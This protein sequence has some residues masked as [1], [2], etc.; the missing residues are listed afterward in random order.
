MKCDDRLSLG[1]RRRGRAA[2]DLG[3]GQ[4]ARTLVV[5]TPERGIVAVGVH[6]EAAVAIGAP[7]LAPQA[8]G[9]EGELIAVRILYGNHPDVARRAQRDRERIRQPANQPHRHFGRHPL[10]GVMGRQEQHVGPSRIVVGIP[11]LHCEDWPPLDRGPD[12][13]DVNQRV[14]RGPGGE[15][16]PD[17]GERLVERAVHR[18]TVSS[19]TGGR[20]A[21]DRRGSESTGGEQALCFG[22]RDDV[23]LQTR[24]RAAQ[25]R[26]LEPQTSERVE[27]GGTRDRHGNHAQLAGERAGQPHEQDQKPNCAASHAGA[28]R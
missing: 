20:G 16:G 8:V 6:A 7:V 18:E 15:G 12:G 19:R 24:R 11:D 2:V 9:R 1:L 3:N 23:R 27:P 25:V 21:G 22:R 4:A 10:A 5:E 17:A 14:G 13:I 28:G 26:H